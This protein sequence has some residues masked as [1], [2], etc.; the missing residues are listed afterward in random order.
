MEAAI[1]ACAKGHQVILCEREGHLGGALKFAD[2]ADFK[3][4][5]L[6][7]RESQIA[8]VKALPIDLR[9]G[10]KDMAALAA[11]AKPDVI[12]AAVGADPI[13][14]PVPGADGKNVV[15]GADMTPDT[16]VGENV[17]VIGGGLVGSEIAL[18]LAREGK[19]V[20]ILEMRDEIAADCSR[21]HKINLVHQL[22]TC[23]N[24]RQAPGYTCTGITENSVTA[25]DAGGAEKAFPA[26]TVIMA[27]GLRPRSGQVEALRPLA[28]EF[29][30]IGDAKAA[31]NV[32]LATREASDA[33]TAMG[34]F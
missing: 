15:T 27:A 4:N 31:G 30:V 23:E 32:R 18:H 22:N 21:M 8:K 34:L 29:Y 7:Y 17:V 5:M 9:L 25:R 33:V 28:P 6:L 2:G 11:E 16:P 14:L 19:K 20:V 24:L 13:I 10:V 26:D 3:R 1:E 12:I